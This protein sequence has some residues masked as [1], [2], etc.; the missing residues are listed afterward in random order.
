M[1]T[2]SRQPKS[3]ARPSLTPSDANVADDHASRADGGTVPIGA[4]IGR[5]AHVVIGELLAAGD[6]K[7]S[8]R[9]TLAAVNGVDFQSLPSVHPHAV[10]QQLVA[11][12]AIYFR[13]FAPSE[14]WK[15]YA[16]EHRSGNCRFDLV[17]RA[18]NG[19]VIV[20]ELKSGRLETQLERRQMQEQVVREVAAGSV[21]WGAAFRGVRVLSL[22]SPRMSCFYDAA[23]NVMDLEWGARA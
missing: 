12:A 17:F 8:L 3:K 16:R 15:L 11:S 22:G 13:F 21:E 2:T 20:D 19:E 18:V 14:D 4:A 5:L 23:G 9:A 7:P 1:S 6:R 10:R